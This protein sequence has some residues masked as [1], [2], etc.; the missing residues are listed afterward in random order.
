MAEAL[1]KFGHDVHVITYH[2]GDK[3]GNHPFRIHRIPDIPFYQNTKP[4]PTFLKLFLL[5]LLLAIKFIRLH[6]KIK[7]D[8]IHSHHYEGLIATLP[9]QL[10]FSTPILYD[11]HTLLLTELH[12]Y[13]IPLPRHILDRIAAT[14]DRTLPKFADHIISVSKSIEETLKILDDNQD[15]LIS[16][17]PNGVEIDL[18]PQKDTKKN[19]G[20]DLV[21]GYAGNFAPYQ[22]LDVL[23]KAFLHIHKSYPTTTLKIYTED[24]PADVLAL[25]GEVSLGAIIRVF[26]TPFDDLPDKLAKTDILLNPRMDGAGHPLKLLNY[27]AA[28]KPIVTFP[29]SAHGLTHNDTAWIVGENSV[30]SFAEGIV[31]LI[32]DRETRVRIGRNARRHVE[33]NHIWAVNAS[34]LTDIYLGLLSK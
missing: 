14:L 17:V 19:M 10:F 2:L 13:N 30:N 22:R 26:K 9:S 8:I 7:F 33:K 16:V 18:F 20:D 28:G 27:M 32:Q 25:I 6:A 1:A 23:L 31:A 21:L 11:A 15:E 29:G 12:H 24:D 5:D 34:I 4:G 3:S